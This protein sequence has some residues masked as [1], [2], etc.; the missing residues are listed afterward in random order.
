MLCGCSLSGLPA[1]R[2]LLKCLLSSGLQRASTDQGSPRNPSA[3]AN[4]LHLHIPLPTSSWGE[5]GSIVVGL[6]PMRQHLP[7]DQPMPQ[8]RS[9]VFLP[10]ANSASRR[11]IESHCPRQQFLMDLSAFSMSNQILRLQEGRLP[12]SDIH[13]KAGNH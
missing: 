4:P 8:H 12:P 3:S 10:E 7:Q 11:E 13:W 2:C 6:S 5:P 9:D 1:V